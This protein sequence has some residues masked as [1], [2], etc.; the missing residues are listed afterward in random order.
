MKTKDFCSFIGNLTK[1]QNRRNDKM[2]KKR[3]LQ[4]RGNNQ[5]SRILRLESLEERQLLTV[6]TAEYDAIRAEYA[7]FG[8]P[9]IMSDVNII[10][11]EEANLSIANLKAAIETAGTTALDDLIVLRT[12]DSANNI[13]YAAASDEISINI[14]AVS[15]GKLSIV[16]FGTVPLTIDAN[17]LSRVMTISASTVNLGN[18]TLT[19]GKTTG[20]GGGILNSSGALTI[21]NST[22]S[23]NTAENYGA[24]INN[25]GMLTVTNSTISGNS[26]TSEYSR[27]GGIYNYSYH[28]A[29][30]LT[31]MN[32]TISGN[33]AKEYGGGIYNDAL[34]TVTNTVVMGN[35][36]K[37]GGGIL[38]FD[39][40]TITNSTV[41]GNSAVY[42]GGISNN[43]TLNIYNTIVTMNYA[44]EGESNIDGSVTEEAN[45]FLAYNPDF[46][47]APIFDANGVLT[48]LESI[49]LHLSP[50]SLAINAGNNIYVTSE[51]TKDRD[52]NDRIYD[53]G[54]VDIGAYEYQGVPTT[55]A[56][57]STVVNSLLDVI[58][59]SD[60][61][62]TLRE[63]IYF[64]TENVSITFDR[65]L[66]DS[67]I[68]LNSQLNIDREITIDASERYITIDAQDHSRVFSISHAA[69]LIGLVITG[70]ISDY[71]GGIYNES[72]LALINCSIVGNMAHMS[73]GGICNDGYITLTNCTVSANSA[74]N[75][76][77]IF[78]NNNTLTLY[79]T[80]LAQNTANVS[81]NDLYQSANNP[82][83]NAY[84]TLSSFTDWDEG[85]NNV[86][87]DAQKPLFLD[88]EN[89]VY[90]LASDSQALNLGDNSYAIDADGNPLLYDIFGN[91]RIFDAIVDIG[92]FENSHL[93]VNTLEDTIDAM[94]GKTSLREAVAI[95]QTGETIT[96]SHKL[97]GLSILLDKGQ[98]NIANAITID[99][100]SLSDSI[101]IDANQASRNFYVGDISDSAPVNFIGLTVTGGK[102]GDDGA[103][104]YNTATLILTNCTITENYAEYY[105][106]GIYNA[107]TLSMESCYV[108]KNIS[109]FAN[110][111]GIFTV[112]GTATLTN[113]TVSEN[114]AYEGG[115]IDNYKGILTLMSCQVSANTAYNGGGINNYQG[116]LSI[117]N[118]LLTANVAE[119]FGAAIYNDGTFVL[120]NS[121]ITANSATGLNSAGG[122]I[123]VSS[124]TTTL[125][126]SIILQNTSNNVSPD[127]YLIGSE[128]YQSYGT[129]IA[130][131]CLSSY[132][133]WNGD[134]NYTYDPEQPLFA[135]PAAGN[136]TLAFDSQAIDK[137]N[138]TYAIDAEGNT[139]L[140]DLDGNTR[141]KNEIVDLGAYEFCIKYLIVNTNED[142]IDYSD[143]KTTL[144]E[145]IEIA[146]TGNI[147]LF[148][149]WLA[150]E[151]ITLDGTELVVSEA[152]IIDASNLYDTDN[153]VPG[154]TVDADEKSRVFNFSGG[155]E[156]LPV[157]LIGL[158]ISG[159]KTTEAGGGIYT[160]AILT[161][162]NCVVSD[163]TSEGGDNS[164]GGGIYNSSGVLTMTN[165]TVSG[166][167]AS[168]DGGGIYNSTGTITLSDSSILQNNTA[169]NGGGLYNNG[170]VTLTNCIVS[171]NTASNDGGGIYNVNGT[172]AIP[173]CVISFNA[174]TANGG[175]IYNASDVLTLAGFTLSTNIALQNGAGIYNSSNDLTLSD[176]L[177]TENIALQNGAGI[178]N[179]SNDLTLSDCLI[180]ENI[181]SSNGGGIFNTSTTISL[182]NIDILH[183]L[184]FAN[185]GGIFNTS[186]AISLT[187]IDISQNL[188]SSDGG[189]LY[190][191]AGTLTMSDCI[192]SQNNID[193]SGSRG[194]GIYSSS[195][196]FILTNCT[197][198]QNATSHNGGGIF[199]DGGTL[200]ISNCTI[201]ENYAYYRGGGIDNTL[202]TL[203]MTNCTVYGNDTD[204]G[205]AIFND[206]GNV[207]IMSSYFY[208]NNALY[209]GGALYNFYGELS[210]TSCI[211][212]ENSA[213]DGG[214]CYNDGTLILTNCTVAANNA[215][216]GGG[217]YNYGSSC[218]TTLYNTIVAQNVATDSENDIYKNA[219]TIVA[220]NS[221][222]SYT[223]WGGQRNYVYD[224][225]QPLFWD[226]EN[227]DYRLAVDSQAI[228]KGNNAN[229]IDF[230]GNTLQF[231]F[232]GNARIVNNIVDLG[233]Y[234]FF[235]LYIVVD[236][237][238]DLIDANDG[239]TTLR[240]AISI[241]EFGNVITF[242]SSLA[243][244]TIVLS[245]MELLLD[246]SIRID[247]TS[248]YDHN[249]NV[250]GITIDAN[251]KSRVFNI[252]G[253]VDSSTVHLIGLTITGGKTT[254][255]GGGIYVETGSL[256]LQSSLLSNNS[257]ELG[258][259]IYSS[260]KK[261]TLT[262]CS[263]FDNAAV[264]GGGIYN[265]S[266]ALNLTNCLL[267]ANSATS[268]GGGIYLSSGDLTLTNNT[269]A[270]NYGFDGVGIYNQ[271]GTLT[272]Y[273][274]IVAL[275]KPTISGDDIYNNAGTINAYNSLSSYTAWG[276]EN[277]Y[278]YDP[279]LTLFWDSGNDNYTLAVDSQAIDRGNNRYAVDSSGMPLQYDLAGNV[280]IYNGIVDLGA[281]EYN[282]TALPLVVDSIEDVIDPN[283]GKTTLR[284]AIANAN[285]GDTITF[286]STL[287]G[288]TIT[289]NGTQLE[290]VKGITIDAS[291][292]SNG[293]TI[294][295]DAKSRV[296]FLTDGTRDNPIQL[297]NLN[298][299]N[300]MVVGGGYTDGGGGIYVKSGYLSI[301]NCNVYSNYIEGNDYFHGGGMY[302]YSAYVTMNNSVVANNSGTTTSG[303]YC[304]GGIY[305]FVGNV[306]MTNC[307]V[308]GNTATHG[309]GIFNNINSTLTLVSSL[310]V[311]NFATY[312]SG[313][314]H[315]DGLL[316]LTNC[317]VAGNTAAENAGG[318]NNYLD[319][320]SLKL[321]NT[322]VAQNI[323]NGS[324]NDIYKA[325]GSIV[326]YNSL[327]SFAD[328]D[329]NSINFVYDSSKPLFMNIQKGD[330][331]LAHYSQATDHGR[332][333][334]AVDAE[335]NPI[336]YDLAGNGR[337]YKNVVDIGAYEYYNYFVVTTVDD[338]VDA[339]DDV[340]SLREA[341]SMTQED[342]F[343][344]FDASLA[345]KTILLNG[346]DILIDKTLSID[347]SS[348]GAEGITIS[349]ANKSNI[350]NV[351]G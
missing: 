167:N 6:T 342:D 272:L 208:D 128:L 316:T 101:I 37:T 282:R 345:G 137:G 250:P 280:R 349:G 274:S 169:S 291:D 188:A 76:G 183:N 217:I 66:L 215:E 107:G 152:V 201:S 89:G 132:T 5:S 149:D 8:L 103:G 144:R 38:N 296:F 74:Q 35:T 228:D 230:E 295:A 301:E 270:E 177:I 200:T 277:N 154:I 49:D 187:N 109:K 305:N 263:V 341:I 309:G 162:M 212:S 94:D 156:N 206:N 202:G 304:G 168:S 12:S 259:A 73:G 110:G 41:S 231:D 238:D 138:N 288:K 350:F 323:A 114:S 290:I 252:S 55:P 227:E 279:E 276:G 81:G 111:G 67:V 286:V 204:S 336:Q 63:A 240:E 62:W 159:G 18:L 245:E 153:N 310:I 50:G 195:D 96:F 133:D 229:A 28:G 271:S 95:A 100:S 122:G 98:I 70:G 260:A 11:I 251:E 347:A 283:D 326:A 140:Y 99:A 92:A 83:I 176:C 246:K 242:D 77:G 265:A 75:G 328:W 241:A 182:T 71:G 148:E 106:A 22:V 65:T 256:T 324:A 44:Q 3:K 171:E 173:D 59:L 25:A 61:F 91:P 307:I 207:K 43:D 302:V 151:T 21:M 299:M 199:N 51:N 141:I 193:G 268:Y 196:T 123:C 85:L 303:N 165:C 82:V 163:N 320:S 172:F 90:V 118:S 34:L 52:G 332:N 23:G 180:T 339:K 56:V 249:N 262:N 10:E 161:M 57:Y 234:E 146:V 253:G 346:G 79:N 221:L 311:D 333:N 198:S 220:Y 294:D 97:N 33:S 317:T 329:N 80:I 40:L 237:V 113:C 284:E 205:G 124:G 287:N 351:T 150:G 179:S 222:S 219:G 281:F 343:I 105:G 322:I 340:L 4:G 248:I 119:N 112:F 318:I 26:A 319:S 72:T 308:S 213:D 185:G 312:K 27:G 273:N 298:V 267:Y 218:T 278:A 32:S 293:I 134:N 160:S 17:Q 87:Y 129:I 158:T 131:N 120:R 147:I 7:D 186:T 203:A 224:P 191:T 297:K 235:V 331:T 68:L 254:D 181:A 78:V 335:G 58:D 175:G 88:A 115:G 31:L 139:L 174:A 47:V 19:G 243:G 233:V 247:A 48:N 117:T 269:V 60:E 197:I 348:L 192:I 86:V 261:L 258:G 127:I 330:Y 178:Y 155:M 93:I 226:I 264:D 314:I 223:A 255:N 184:A 306:T 42:V 36:A 170:A 266:G 143:D 69:T 30:S 315:N 157:T 64:A 338:V 321:Y 29:C 39:S 136:Y 1:F 46:V 135:N 211:L 166:N 344:V 334:Y 325:D 164:S 239:K 236:S 189:G 130:Y 9:E 300:G 24:G 337:I 327:S 257:A 285:E 145:A 2:D 84:N 53:E 210:L 126:N 209:Y 232:A 214:A 20:D 108:Y 292:L 225:A 275:N 313:G 142:N 194:G 216:E 54:V 104:I 244:K 190:N 289:L 116:T 121:T 45:N 125:Y 13:T 102:I 15:Y 14:D 16:G